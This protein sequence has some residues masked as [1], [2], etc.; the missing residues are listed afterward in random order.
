MWQGLLC[1]LQGTHLCLDR[2]PAGWAIPGN[3]GLEHQKLQGKGKQ[4]VTL[5]PNPTQ[6]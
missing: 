4:G 5:G 3:M 2:S 6:Q 1:H